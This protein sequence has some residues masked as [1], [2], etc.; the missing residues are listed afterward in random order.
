MFDD[1]F[2]SGG[3]G[4][5]SNS[6]SFTVGPQNDGTYVTPDAALPINQAVDVGSGTAVG[7][8]APDVFKLLGAGLNSFTTLYGQNQLL[9]Y[10]RYEAT[11]GGIF[12]QGQAASNIASAQIAAVN[13]NK[14]LMILGLF[15][16]MALAIHKG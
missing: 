6:Y 4:V 1:L 15:A 7:N 14:M 8:Y 16:V 13:S 2:S 10:K 9:D 12:A 5:G 11:Q 3:Y